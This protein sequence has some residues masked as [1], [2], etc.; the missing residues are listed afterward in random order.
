MALNWQGV[1]IGHGVS[2]E[3]RRLHDPNATPGNPPPVVGVAYRHPNGKSGECEGWVPFKDR[4]I[5]GQGWDVLSE[6][7]LTLSPSLL[8]RTCGHHGFIRNGQ[9]VP[10]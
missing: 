6:E 10:A 9:W 2:I 8:C 1:D 4:Y 5:E 7:P 3:L